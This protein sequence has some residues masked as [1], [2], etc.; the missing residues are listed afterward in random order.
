[1]EQNISIWQELGWKAISDRSKDLVIALVIACIGLIGTYMII[2]RSI[3]NDINTVETSNLTNNNNAF[4]TMSLQG[5]SP[6]LSNEGL[7]IIQ[8]NLE[9]EEMLK[10]SYMNFNSSHKYLID[11][12]NGLRNIVNSASNYI[13]YQDPG[14]YYI[15]FYE[16]VDEKWKLLSTQSVSIKQE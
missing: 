7:L 9:P 6:K 13:K 15:L 3:K 10:V 2:G 11:Y 14:V 8:G 5:Q 1:M 12:G 4:S 16:M